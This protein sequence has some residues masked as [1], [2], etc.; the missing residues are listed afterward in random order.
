M[1]I[2]YSISGEKEK[3]QQVLTGQMT[4]K[5]PKRSTQIARQPTGH[6]TR[7]SLGKIL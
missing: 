4:M 1:E 2:N 6:I 3:V 5:F 7:G